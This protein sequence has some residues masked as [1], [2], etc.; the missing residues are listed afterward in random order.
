ME[1]D[2]KYESNDG[3]S[4]SIWGCPLWF[5]L[6]MISFNYPVHP[7]TE[8]RKHYAGF[9]RYLGYVLPCGLCRA[10]YQRIRMQRKHFR[11]RHTLSRFI[12]HIHNTIPNCKPLAV[13]Y[14]QMRHTYETFRSHCGPKGC[15]LPTNFV[16]SQTLV[17]VVPF[18][19]TVAS[20]QVSPF[21][22]E[23]K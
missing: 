1:D 2:A 6:H 15:V 12:Y 20:F 19:D 3:F 14:E 8:D 11:S 18:N 4:T 22:F 16:R 21:C 9:F 10:N 23:R 5:V 13:T 17:R 7:T